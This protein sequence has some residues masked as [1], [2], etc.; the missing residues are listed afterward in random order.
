M[1]Y[2]MHMSINDCQFILKPAIRLI[3]KND[4]LRVLFLVELSEGFCL[5]IFY[6][7]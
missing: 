2:Y 1:T 4:S 7:L 5:N 6:A 3:K